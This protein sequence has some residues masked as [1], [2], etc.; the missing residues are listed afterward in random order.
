MV[1]GDVAERAIDG[2]LAAVAPRLV[3]PRAA[4]TAILDELRDGLHE[5]VAARIRSGDEMEA[6]LRAALDEFGA[7][8]RTAAAFAGELAGSA[9]AER[10]WPTWEAV[11]LSDSCGC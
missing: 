3:G 11:R 7:P 10:C 1:G 8:A 5:A 2:Y 6:A 4:R 9:P